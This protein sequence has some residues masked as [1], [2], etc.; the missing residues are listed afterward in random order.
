LHAWLTQAAFRL[1]NF[2]PK[3]KSYFAEMK[4]KPKP[5]YKSGFLVD[6]NSDAE[7]VGRMLPQP[8]IESAGQK[9]FLLDELFGQDFALLAYG[10]GAQATLSLTDSCDFGIPSLRKIAILPSDYNPDP[11]IKSPGV[12]VRDIGNGFGN[13]RSA[14]GDCVILV[15]P[16]RYIAAAA[17]SEPGAI[18]AM[19]DRV[20]A[21][22]ESCGVLQPQRLSEQISSS[23][24]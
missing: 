24:A 1:M 4:Y 5:F 18:T 22:V 2:A 21:L 20:R 14:I 6:D 10:P 17:T 7:V 11:G 9:P 23:A 12:V 8:M 13:F 3:L 19:A 15:R 16:D